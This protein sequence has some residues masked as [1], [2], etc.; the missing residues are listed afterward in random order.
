M[1]K[2]LR[3]DEDFRHAVAASTRDWRIVTTRA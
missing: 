2:A 3:K 1:I